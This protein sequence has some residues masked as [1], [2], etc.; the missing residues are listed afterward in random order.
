MIKSFSDKVTAALVYL[1]LAEIAVALALAVDCMADYHFYAPDCDTYALNA[2]MQ[3]K[4]DNEF[5][6]IEEYLSLAIKNKNGTASPTDKKNFEEYKRKYSDK[7]TNIVFTVTDESGNI[8]LD[9]LSEKTD[10]LS[11]VD[12]CFKTSRSFSV[13][14]END[15]PLKGTIKIIVREDMTAEDGYRLASRLIG[16]AKVVK[17]PI[18]VIFI[19]IAFAAV[20]VLG[21]LM[22]SI[23]RGYTGIEDD[24]SEQP[25]D[26]TNLRFLDKIPFD[27]LIVI[28][29]A[30][31]AFIAALIVLTVVA[32]VKKQNLV[33]WNAVILVLAFVISAVML[34]FDLTLASRIKRG[35]V[36]KNTLVYRL[37]AKIRAKGGKENSGYF[38]VPFFGKAIITIGIITFTDVGILLY[39]VFRYV[40]NT[41]GLLSDFH[42]LYYVLTQCVFI[43]TLGPLFLMMAMNL[44]HV[45]ESGSRLVKGDFDYTPDSHIM[46]G[47][48]KEISE[49]L[50]D[51]KD[52]MIKAY[53][54]REKSREVRNELIT[55]L[56]HD[57]KTPLTSIINYVGILECNAETGEDNSEY[58]EILKN[59][60]QKLNT[61]LNDLIE[62]S[63]L[64]AGS[65]TAKIEP[66]NV[67]LLLSQT[68]DEFADKLA[69][70]QLTVENSVEEKDIIVM[71]DG[72]KLWR[73]FAN[74]IGNINKYA[75]PGTRVYIDAE[76]EDG[77]TRISFKNISKQKIEGSGEELIRR[78]KRG[79]TSRHGD[80]YGLGLAIAESM[81]ELQGGSLDI[82]V[83]GDLFKAVLT[84]KSSENK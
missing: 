78:F 13:F 52:D 39:F 71:A 4:T 23:G 22:N 34:V 21:M 16:A 41:S 60:A 69:E 76:E 36:Y 26:T 57:I 11:D 43:L 73:I 33:L 51:I 55:N 65:E 74:L 72:D 9:N 67:S 61:L 19:V 81:A 5:P 37:I 6:E 8:I 66:L 25:D 48:F 18:I 1:L 3:T 44:Y 32:D 83:D 28:M 7:N 40:T 45:K 2:T 17:Y 38:K 50:A 30:I 70:N 56:S 63:R 79:D 46:F 14:D 75:L 62:V 59:Q 31:I 82:T 54:E 64:S 42:F 15:E 27:L 68:L 12:A 80:G 10:S 20:I 24:G 84:L 58:F 77:N 35:H 47:D 29:L 53:E 49:N